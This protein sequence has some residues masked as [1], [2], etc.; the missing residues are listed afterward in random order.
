METFS[1][2]LA[3]FEG[4]GGGGGGGIHRSPDAEL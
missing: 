2:L 4:G 3:L 1:A